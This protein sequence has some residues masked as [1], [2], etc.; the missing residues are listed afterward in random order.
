MLSIEHFEEQQISSEAFPFELLMESIEENTELVRDVTELTEL[1]SDMLERKE[2]T[3]TTIEYIKGEDITNPDVVEFTEEI[4][5]SDPNTVEACV[6]AHMSA[7]DSYA[8]ILTGMKGTKEKLLAS[9]GLSYS[10]ENTNVFD[11]Y[12][13]VHE[14]LIAT[15]VVIVTKIKQFFKRI[16]KNIIGLGRSFKAWFVGNKKTDTELFNKIHN[17]VKK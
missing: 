17:N 2:L 5:E 8:K 12:K 16:F 10:K 1:A 14:G 6:E 4:I 11:R 9:R 3:Q 7:L 15:L 13:L